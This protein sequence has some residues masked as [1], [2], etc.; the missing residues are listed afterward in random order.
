M[1]GRTPVFMICSPRPRVG[2]TLLARALVEF[3]RANSRPVSAFDVNP[4]EFALVEDLIGGL[5]RVE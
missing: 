1:Q 5:S 3:F 4:D 2:K